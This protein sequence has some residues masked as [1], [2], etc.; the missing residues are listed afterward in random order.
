M[1]VLT[2]SFYLS[3]CRLADFTRLVLGVAAWREYRLYRSQFSQPDILWKALDEIVQ[4]LH[5]SFSLH[6]SDLNDSANVLHE[7]DTFCNVFQQPSLKFAI[8]YFHGDLC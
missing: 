4:D 3:N 8:N 2:Q 6:L 5:A 1:F 7:F